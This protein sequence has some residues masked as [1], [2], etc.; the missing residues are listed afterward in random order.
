MD[1]QWS[2]VIIEAKYTLDGYSVKCEYTYHSFRTD[3][4]YE[5]NTFEGAACPACFIVNT[6]NRYQTYTGSS[7]WTN[8]AVEDGQL[9]IINQGGAIVGR[10]T[11]ERWS[12]VYKA[13]SNQAIGIYM[14]TANA[15]E[16][17]NMKQLEVYAENE[18]GTEFTGGFTYFDMFTTFDNI[19]GNRSN[20]SKTIV[21]NVVIAENPQKVRA[22]VYRLAGY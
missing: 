11:K 20:Y 5:L 17:S 15:S 10:H 4:Q 7:P 14:P 2:E 18:P 22:E 16:Y 3:G 12:C 13:N 1:S 8:S 9:P 21:T 6:L 19:D